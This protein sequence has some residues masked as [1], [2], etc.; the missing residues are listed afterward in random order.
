MHPYLKRGMVLFS[1]VVILGGAGLYWKGTNLVRSI[2][3][4]SLEKTL[5]PLGIHEVEIDKLSFGSKK[6]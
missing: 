3:K 5:S 4:E 1:A 2:A 6:V